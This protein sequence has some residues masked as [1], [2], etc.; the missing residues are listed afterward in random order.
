MKIVNLSD[1]SPEWNWLAS[2]F[3][4]QSQDWKHYSSLS[5]NL[6]SLIP[7][8][9][10]I[11]RVIAA[12][13]AVNACKKNSSILV[14]HGPRPAMYA[15][16]LAGLIKPNLLHLVYSFNF[17]DL[18]TGK[19]R[20]L[21][22]KAYQQP[23]KFVSYSTVEQTLYADYFDIPIEK[24][25]M[26]HWAVHVPK[27]D[28]LEKP[29]E[30][31][32][33][34]CALGSQGRDYKTLFAAMKKLPNIK[35]ILVASPD[36]I[37]DLVVPNN[38]KMYTNIPLS[39][40]HNI[41]THSQFMVLPL[42]DSQVPCGHVTIVSGMFF[43]KAILVTNSQGVH[44]YITDEKTGLFFEPKNADDLAKKIES[45]WDDTRRTASLSEAG[46]TFANTHCTEKTA[47][48]YFT[49]FIQ[50]FS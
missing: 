14:S 24:I 39:Q 35:L 22:A 8:K 47:V 27:I 12:I 21:M 38:V 40:A 17:T 26:L 3:K 31:G 2:E 44:D 16:N 48:N 10:S 50:Q 19:Q 18:P 30:T 42:R 37:K 34:I 49:H 11:S 29:I 20:Q 4:L 15:G 1:L 43:K 25:D 36:S 9:D 41:L 33:Y 7:K 45:L 28:L 5:I 23:T 46:F 13:Q 6:P 32:S